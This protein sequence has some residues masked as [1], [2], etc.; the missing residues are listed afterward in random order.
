MIIVVY[1]CVVIAHIATT[2][3][4]PYEKVQSVAVD[5]TTNTATKQPLGRAFKT[6][7]FNNTRFARQHSFPITCFVRVLCKEGERPPPCS[8]WKVVATGVDA[9]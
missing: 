3:A 7:L 4:I 6:S 8:W 9:R 2:A 1:K 5:L